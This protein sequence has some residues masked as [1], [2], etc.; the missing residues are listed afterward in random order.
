M[1]KLIKVRVYYKNP[2]DEKSG[3]MKMRE[4]MIKWYRENKT[5]SPYKKIVK[6]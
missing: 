6:I 5:S 3:T 4:S 1:D 2:L